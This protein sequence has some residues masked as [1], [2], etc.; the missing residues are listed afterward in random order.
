MSSSLLELPSLEEFHILAAAV[1]ICKLA[2]VPGQILIFF[3]CIY[4]DA[5]LKK[6]DLRSILFTLIDLILIPTALWKVDFDLVSFWA[7]QSFVEP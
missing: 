7:C 5:A 4:C 1:L 2:F 6:L 3:S